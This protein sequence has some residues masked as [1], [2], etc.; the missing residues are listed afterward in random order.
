M[1]KTK[2]LILRTAGTNCDWET[3]HG[4]ALAGATP[5]RVHISRLLEGSVSLFDY[6][7]LV[8]PGGFSYGDDLSAGKVLANEL[9]FKLQDQILSFAESGRPII[10]ICNGFQVLVKTGLLPFSRERGSVC[11]TLTFNDSG[12][13]EARWIYLRCTGKSPLLAG[14]SGETITLPVAHGEGK[15]LTGDKKDLETLRKNGQVALQY[16][17]PE[18]KE[19]LDYPE[20]PNGSAK[21]IAAVTNE[22]GN[23][24]GMMPHPERFLYPYC[25]PAW[26]RQEGKSTD[27]L[28]VLKSIVRYAQ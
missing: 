3:E 23:I 26:T 18:G 2:V 7:I 8:I 20:N 13:F 17:T 15:F 22:K 27:G 4:F 6:G 10:G 25:H 16:A 5:E 28:R 21:A 24:L 19:T 9:R 11:A 1:K 14:L 12:R